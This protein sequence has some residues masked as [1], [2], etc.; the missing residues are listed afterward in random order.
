MV[1]VAV[2]AALIGQL[3][4]ARAVEM[5]LDPYPHELELATVT[6]LGFDRRPID[7]VR[8]ARNPDTGRWLLDNGDGVLRVLPP[9]ME[10]PLTPADYGLA[11][12]GA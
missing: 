7:T 6:F 10:L 2:V 11:M 4:E 12:P 3:T 9:A 5:R 8:V 1:P